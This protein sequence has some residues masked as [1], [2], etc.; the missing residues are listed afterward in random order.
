[1]KPI[2]NGTQIASIDSLAAMLGVTPERLNRV[3][4]T[5]PSSYK[6][7]SVYTGKNRKERQLFEPKKGLKHI[8]KK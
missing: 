1:M 2:F 5:I 3:V 4:S 7:F 8:Q 6:S